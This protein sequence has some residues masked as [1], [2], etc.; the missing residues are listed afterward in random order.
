MKFKIEPSDE[1]YTYNYFVYYKTGLFGKWKLLGEKIGFMK[2]DDCIKVI[3]D[4]KQANE[5]IKRINKE[6]EDEI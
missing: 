4:F 1:A 5:K 2:L 6:L 3:K